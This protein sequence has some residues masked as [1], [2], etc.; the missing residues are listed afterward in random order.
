VG[1][2]SALLV[3]PDRRRNGVARLLLKAASQA[4]RSAGCWE[5]VLQAPT[6]SSD[7]RVFCLAKG[8]VESGETFSRCFAQALAGV[9]LRTAVQPA[10]S[11]KTVSSTASNDGTL[12]KII[13]AIAP[14]Q[15]VSCP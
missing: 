2:I 4:A 12:P 7:L 9:I 13:A 6:G 14:H 3:D 1:W 11:A 5:L 8:F 10:S 15:V